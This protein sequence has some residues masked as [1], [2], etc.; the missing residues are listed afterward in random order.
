M[1]IVG[2]ACAPGAK[3]AIYEYLVLKQEDTYGE[4]L[5]DSPKNSQAPFDILR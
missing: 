2:C 3:S 4:K 1:H 5:R